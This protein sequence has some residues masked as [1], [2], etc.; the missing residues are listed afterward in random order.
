MVYEPIQSMKKI[1]S[2]LDADIYD[3]DLELFHPPNWLND[4]C[5]NY[6][7]R[8]IAHKFTS[9]IL[10]DPSVV[11]FLRIQCEDNEEFAELAEGIELHS[12]TWLLI[13]INDS[14]SFE[15]SST[16]W[17][18]LLVHIPSCRIFHY[19]SSE[20]YNRSAA[21]GTSKQVYKL[22]KK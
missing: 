17:S 1:L 8:R 10:M 9:I 12:K 18:L 13:P 3:R 11:S 6:C 21:E 5:I 2:L 4:R 14:D 20:F 7:F 15:S 22:L 19:D 16:H